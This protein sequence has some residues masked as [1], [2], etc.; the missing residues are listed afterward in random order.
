MELR[1]TPLSNFSPS[2]KPQTKEKSILFK[3]A[4]FL[5]KN[6]NSLLNST[7]NI[8]NKSKSDNTKLSLRLNVE[9]KQVQS[10]ERG[11]KKGVL[12]YQQIER[13]KIFSVGSE[14]IN[15]FHYKV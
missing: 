2:I 10:Q 1:I 5:I 4:D 6:N 12:L 11:E 9:P 15:R 8:S 14:L 13:N 7:N 3:S